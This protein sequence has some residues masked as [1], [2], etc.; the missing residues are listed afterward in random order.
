MTLM[1]LKVRPRQWRQ[2]IPPS[3]L[4]HPPCLPRKLRKCACVQFNATRARCMREYI[5]LAGPSALH[6]P[7]QS[8]FSDT[9]ARLAVKLLVLYMVAGVWGMDA[10]QGNGSGSG[11]G[12]GSASGSGSGISPDGEP[13]CLV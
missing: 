11:S 12:S 7:K 1:A 10:G 4:R 6:L 8:V 9:M 13:S 2:Q 5:W 3:A